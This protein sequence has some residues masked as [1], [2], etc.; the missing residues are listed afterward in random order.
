MPAISQRSIERTTDADLPQD[1]NKDIVSLIKESLKN[2]TDEGTVQSW[3]ERFFTDA[4]FRSTNTCSNSG[5]KK[6]INAIKLYN[7]FVSDSRFKISSD[8][9]K[10]VTEQLFIHIEKM[11]NRIANPDRQLTMDE[12]WHCDLFDLIPVLKYLFFMWQVYFQ[13]I[14]I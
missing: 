7:F 14:N 12:F 3:G 1:E 4:I 6:I 8:D 13:T 2:V 10:Q 9:Q 11:L 5:D